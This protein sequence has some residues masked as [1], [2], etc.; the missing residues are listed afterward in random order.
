MSPPPAV[1]SNFALSLK[2]WVKA[3]HGTIM[4]LQGKDKLINKKHLPAK[5]PV[6]L[7][8]TRPIYLRHDSYLQYSFRFIVDNLIFV[9]VI[10]S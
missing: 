6:F 4:I 7:V 2:A 1:M 5:Q 9:A 8:W 10:F 3:G